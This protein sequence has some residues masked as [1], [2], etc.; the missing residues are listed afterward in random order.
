MQERLGLDPVGLPA[1]LAE[2]A[3][4]FILPGGLAARAAVRLSR[5]GRLDR[6]IKQGRAIAK[7]G[8]GRS[9]AALGGPARAISKAERRILLAQ[10]AG[11]AT[12]ADAVV[13]SDAPPLVILLKVVQLTDRNIGLTGSEEALRL[14]QNKLK[15]GAKLVRYLLVCHTR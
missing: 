10:Q 13:A 2:V 14:L 1:E 6:A 15:I 12:I 4:Q 8:G 5:L 9:R 7:P 3:T 11:A